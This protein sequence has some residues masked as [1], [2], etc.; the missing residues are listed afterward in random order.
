MA[1]FRED[2]T[3]G[4]AKRVAGGT[5]ESIFQPTWS[6]DNLLYFVSDRTGWW[7]LYRYMEGHGEPL[8]PLEAEFGLP[9]W[10][11]GVRTYSFES[12]DYI[13]GTYVEKGVWHL[14]RLHTTTGE[15]QNLS[16]PY[17]WLLSPLVTFDNQIVVLAASPRRDESII[18]IDPVKREYQI[19]C[20]SSSLFL[21]QAYLSV[22]RLIE[23]PTA[24]EQTAFAYYY[25]PSNP[26]YRAPENE[27]PPLIVTA[28]GGPT[29]ST[30]D[31]LRLAIQ[32]WT[33]RGFAVVDVNYGGSTGHGREYRQ[34]LEG[35]WGVVDVADVVHAARY[36]VEKG[37][38]DPERLAV[39]GGS[40]GGFTTMAALAFSD[41]FSAGVSYFGVSDLALL[42]AETHK[43][44]S[45]YLDR[46]VGPFPETEGRYRERSPLFALDRF[47]CPLLLLQGQKDKV[48]PPDQAERI[49]AALEEKGVPVAYVLF[50]DEAHGF[51]SRESIIRSL[52]SELAFY[53]RVFGFQPADELPELDIRNLD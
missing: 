2:G 53:G 30:N 23:F 16:L 4:P 43:F 35:Q 46:L 44:E 15:R 14:F 5:D 21:D 37:L 40:A 26:R 34:R 11:L 24:D 47:D 20:R 32:F 22:P 49:L 7:N 10:S 8:C 45:R 50:P 36:L 6:P 41:V 33:S 27:R 17:T 52:E 29:S 42:A 18:R 9:L 51:R 31:T 12:P 38:A 48:V 3:L 1:T 19:I 13:I 28:H 39:R 25:S